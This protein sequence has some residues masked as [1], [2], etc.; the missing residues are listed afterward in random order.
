MRFPVF[1]E[2]VGILREIS[3]EAIKE[4]VRHEPLIVVAGSP[5][6]E[7][8]NVFRLLSGGAP[9]GGLVRLVRGDFFSGANWDLLQRAD[10]VV[11]V[12][13]EQ[14][15]TEGNGYFHPWELRDAHERVLVVRLRGD[16]CLAE[17]LERTLPED[18]SRV[19][20]LNLASSDEEE[21]IK[22]LFPEVVRMLDDH[23]LAL[24][25]FLPH[26]RE[27]VSERV[28]G[29]T[30]RANAEFALLSNIPAA[31]PVLGNLV[32]AGADFIVLTKNQLVMLY[33]LAAI[34]GRNLDSKM[35]I[36]TEM[37]PVVGSAF[38]WRTIARELADLLPPVIGAIPKTT[39]A[40]S[41]TFVVGKAAHY[42]YAKG[43]KPQKE[44]FE[45][46]YRQALAQL[47]SI[48]LRKP[49]ALP[50]LSAPGAEPTDEIL[51]LPGNQ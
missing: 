49:K 20:A 7:A 2:L 14:A 1:L 37:I 13:K 29:K 26:F 18:L 22:R 36:Y 8:Y 17:G 25:R 42:Y 30:S 12:W 10:L 47:K 50:S 16:A 38:L 4:Q 43:V 23:Q 6:G 24:A 11:Y 45:I 40:Y 46:F 27:V 41:G 48:V 33:K 44:M 28:I 32:A 19:R 9:D 15:S 5:L 39:I 21:M 35:Q 31:I 34:Y 3:L 51:S